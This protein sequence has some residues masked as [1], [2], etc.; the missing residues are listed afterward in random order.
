MTETTELSKPDPAVTFMARRSE[1]KLVKKPERRIKNH[2]GDVVEVVPGERLVFRDGVLKLPPSGKAR[3]EKGEAIDATETIA[4]LE[5]HPLL[6]DKNEGFWKH[7]EPAPA[8]SPEEIDRLNGLAMRRDAKGIELLISEEQQGWKRS[9]YLKSA[10]TSL[11]QVNEL[12]AEVPVEV[13]AKPVGRP[14]K[15]VE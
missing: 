4:W 5:D 15:S 8:P 2:E 14:K 7:N 3:G 10:E 12:L 11:A 6:N 1:L 9:G 13:T